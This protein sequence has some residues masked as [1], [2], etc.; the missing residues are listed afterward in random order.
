MIMRLGLI[1]TSRFNLHM[2]SIKLNLLMYND[3]PFWVVFYE[4]CLPCGKDP[5]SAVSLLFSNCVCRTMWHWLPNFSQIISSPSSASMTKNCWNISQA[6]KFMR[7]W[8]GLEQA[9]QKH[10]LMIPGGRWCVQKHPE[11]A[12]PDLLSTMHGTCMYL[13]WSLNQPAECWSSTRRLT[14][15]KIG[16]ACSKIEQACKVIPEN[17]VQDPYMLVAERECV[18][19]EEEWT[20]AP[21]RGSQLKL[22]LLSQS[23][24]PLGLEFESRRV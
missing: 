2:T 15:R 3:Y 16:Y 24:E 12:N 11:I 20:T 1:S 19:E 13:P 21:V 23:Y 10:S 22:S 14:A 17:L 5:I 4:V 18:C 9:S 6:L 8:M 7:E